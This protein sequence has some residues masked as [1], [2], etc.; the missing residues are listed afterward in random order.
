M[1]TIKCVGIHHPPLQ[2]IDLD[3]L[4]GELLILTGPKGS[5]TKELLSIMGGYTSPQ[6]GECLF[7][8]KNLAK[9][10]LKERESI[11]KNEIGVLFQ[12]GGWIGWLTVLENLMLPLY[13]AGM[14]KKQAK[15]KAEEVLNLLGLLPLA[16][17]K[18]SSLNT[19]E[20]KILSIV[21]TSILGPKLLLLEE[22]TADLD[23]ITAVKICTYLRQLACEEDVTIVALI[24]DARL[25]AFAHRI[26]HLRNGEITDIQGEALLDYPSPPYLQI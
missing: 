14:S 4:E 9:V 6:R 19:S 2:N 23:H 10:S 13:F 25:F 18:A 7:F 5:G 20:Q 11:Q 3:I 21:K 24:N 8:E 22:P 1:T 15:I 12:K 16:Q 26:V 17:E